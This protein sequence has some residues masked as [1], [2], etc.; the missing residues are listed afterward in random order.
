MTTEQLDVSRKAKPFRPFTLHLTDGT[1]HEVSHPELTWRTPGGRTIF[2]NL[3]GEKI[4]IIDLLL[5]AQM[6]HCNG[7]SARQRKRR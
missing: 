1:K 3:G 2:V 6:S 5:V 7:S 4:A